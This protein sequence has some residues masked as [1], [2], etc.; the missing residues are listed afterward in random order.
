MNR[1]NR[2]VL[3]LAAY[4][5]ESLHLT[6]E[7]L[8]HTLD[9]EE[10]V[11]IVLNGRRGIRSAIVEDVARAWC[12]KGAN[13]YVVKPLNY[14]KDA[15][16]SISQVIDQFPLLQEVEFICKIDD[17]LIPLKKGWVDRLHESYLDMERKHQSIG[18]VTSLINNN[19]WG[20]KRL[21]DLYDKQ[22][23]YRSIMN[24]ESLSGTGNVAA[25]GIAEGRLGSVWQ[26]PYLAKWIHEWTLCSVEEYINKTRLLGVEEVGL[27]VHYS[28]GCM[29]FRK[30]LWLS[31]PDLHSSSDFDELLIHEY[32]QK[33]GLRK[34]A[35]MSEP[36]GHLFY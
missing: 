10:K 16:T 23:E 27:D 13:R 24:F 33:F 25:G 5:Y 9:G 35:L 17:D 8:T 20:F 18:F 11:V 36:M 28:I 4:D 1:N 32:C 34:F 29:F 2:V 22:N 19:A 26:Y 30:Q 6:L 31:L 3:L 15:Y 21:V 7:S 14:G 12:G